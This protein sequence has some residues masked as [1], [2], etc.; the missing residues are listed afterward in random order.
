MGAVFLLALGL[1]DGSFVELGSIRRKCWVGETLKLFLSSCSCCWNLR[2]M[3][4][5]PYS[6]P[7]ASDRNTV[8]SST[9]S[10]HF[11]L[12]LC[13]SKLYKRKKFCLCLFVSVSLS[14][15]PWLC[16]SLSPSLHI[17][18]SPFPTT[19]L[20]SHSGLVDSFPNLSLGC[21]REVASCAITSGF[22]LCNRTSIF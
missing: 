13:L 4:I 9:S 17:P 3:Q 14:L 21:S 15:C 2:V 10:F 16:V 8:S 19:A 18:V 11:L 6:P 20:S 22:C 1:R 5:L 12:S 7:C